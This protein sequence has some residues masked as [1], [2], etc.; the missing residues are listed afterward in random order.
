M[1]LEL[2]II[3]VNELEHDIYI[4]CTFFHEH[5]NEFDFIRVFVESDIM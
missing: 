3:L 4:K 1:I 2:T 5:D